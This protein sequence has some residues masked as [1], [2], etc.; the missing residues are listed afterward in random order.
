[1]GHVCG[2]RWLG[3]KLSRQHQPGAKFPQA[4]CR[5]R[6]PAASQT[7][8]PSALSN[9]KV[10]KPLQRPQAP[11]TNT[12]PKEPSSSPDAK[13]VHTVPEFL[14]RRIAQRLRSTYDEKFANPSKVSSARFC[15]D[16]WHVPGQYTQMRTPAQV[17][18][19]LSCHLYHFVYCTVHALLMPASKPAVV[20][21]TY[22]PLKRLYC[23]YEGAN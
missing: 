12:S 22:R 8:A 15:W 16:Y 4:F 19:L 3:C 11:E 20:D 9:G 7:S 23:K 6:P 13:H 1:M 21:L 17:R 2:P 14:D 10:G 5:A 18:C